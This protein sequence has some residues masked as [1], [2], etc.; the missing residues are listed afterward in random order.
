MIAAIIVAAG[1]GR[2]MTAPTPKQYLMVSHRPI[3][4]H[5]LLKF[6]SC[7]VFQQ[8]CLVVAAQEIE[9]CRKEI[10]APLKL[11]T[12]V[13]LVPGGEIR[14]ASVY[15]GLKALPPE[16][17]WVVVHDGVRPFVTA[18]QIHACIDGARLNGAC[19]LGIPITETLKR[20]TGTGEIEKTLE[21]EM[22][23]RQ[24]RA[25]SGMCV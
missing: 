13:N 15:N 12:P 22:R 9:K 16:T 2:R 1:E 3:L 14:Q 24:N 19:S 6:E 7:G 5:T 11:S 8:I 10:L 18:E 20:V 17:K 25:E 4:E 21:R 23:D